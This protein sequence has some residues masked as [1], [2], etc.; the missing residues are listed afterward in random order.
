ME[1][2]LE[3]AVVREELHHLRRPHLLGL[4]QR[5]EADVRGRVGGVGEGAGQRVQVVGADGDEGP[6]PGQVLV[7]LVLRRVGNVRLLTI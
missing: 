2:R 6:L 7:Q 1:V 3:V 4:V 5:P